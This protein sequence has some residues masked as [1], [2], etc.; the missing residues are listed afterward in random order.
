MRFISA[1][2]LWWLL[3]SLPIILFY[4]LK[5]KRTRRVVPSVL[6]WAR[7][8]EEL[9]AN[10]P[11]RKLR[12]SLLL[13]LQLLFLAAIVVAVARPLVI[14]RSLAAG[15]TIIIIDSTASMNTL[16][17]AGGSRLERARQI[18]HEM[19]AGLRASDRAA[20]IES[21]SRVTLRSALS[22]DRAA[23]DN[24]IDQVSSTDT[25]GTLK[26]AVRLA[27][28]MA[29]SEHDASIVI[30]S[31]GAGVTTGLENSSAQEVP[32]QNEI[33]RNNS[34][35]R[36]VRVGNRSENL[37]I[38][39]MISRARYDGRQELF[40][41]VSNFSNADKT[42]DVDLTVD[43]R[44]IDVRSIA[45]PP[46]QVGRLVFDSLPL[47]GGLSELKLNADDELSSDN[48]AFCFVAPSRRLRV[49]VATEDS[50]LLR[51]LAV[52]SQIDARRIEKADPSL[53]EKF[54]CLV[55]SGTS[56]MEAL[57][58]NRPLLVINPPDLSPL[59]HSIGK[60]ER[61]E[62][63]IVA[64]AHPVN[65]YLS[66][67]DMHVESSPRLQTAPWLRP[68]VSTSYGDGLLW[69]GDDGRRRVVVV[70]FDLSASDMPLKV[71]FPIFVANAISWLSGGDKSQI[72]RD[73]RAGQ[74]VTI[75][76]TEKGVRVAAP[77]GE[78]T[79]LSASSEG[80]IVFADTLRVGRYE[81]SGAQSF[82]VSLLSAT[83]SNNT[84]RDSIP[85]RGGEIAAQRETFR[86]EREA[87]RWIAMA[88]LMI[89][90]FEWWAYQRRIG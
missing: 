34:A 46:N 43:G 79:D 20:I 81:V 77:D 28:Q 68:I 71:E 86:S 32:R 1:S 85:G 11:F 48:I 69:A 23:L 35:L 80:A 51:A 57:Q 90:G 83:E 61:P 21:S 73:V 62:P 3:L 64:R 72:P 7:A 70:G 44:L 55:V 36:F 4:L 41:S 60:L 65:A 27:E 30:I 40:A 49:G 18:A 66:Y 2:A 12:R 31:D 47:E 87:W 84:P 15:N 6:L 45:I 78:L 29:A 37:G 10:S 75:S 50:F 19:V 74:P 59:C 22:P 16:D 39:S 5:L 17:E 25:A 52:D 82:G 13:L 9:E 24:A 58:G 63:A 56:S 42:V 38:T 26:D 54:D 33:G 67:A 53:I 88:G 89:L 76:T 8:V 14:S